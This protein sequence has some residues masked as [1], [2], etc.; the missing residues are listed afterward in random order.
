M[1]S[2]NQIK[3]KRRQLMK[4]LRKQGEY[5]GECAKGKTLSE[6]D[7]ATYAMLPYVEMIAKVEALE[8]VLEKRRAI[9]FSDEFKSVKSERKSQA[10]E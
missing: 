3:N 1:K 6:K 7:C 10:N 9:S 4:D 2:E 8:W 5:I